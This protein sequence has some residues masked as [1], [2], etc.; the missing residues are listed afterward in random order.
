MI[1]NEPKTQKNSKHKIEDIFLILFF[2]AFLIAIACIIYFYEMEI[3]NGY[4]HR[5]TAFSTVISKQFD[6][7]AGE[8]LQL[9]EYAQ[10][11]LMFP[12]SYKHIDTIYIRNNEDQEIF[13]KTLYTGQDT[14]KT[15]RLFC[16]KAV[17]SFQG[18]VISQPESCNK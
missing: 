9:K 15:E 18:L 7:P 6:G 12:Y 8:H 4:K 16:A 2:I 10:S 13:V 11:S 14:Y 5:R 17:Y 1:D 3:K